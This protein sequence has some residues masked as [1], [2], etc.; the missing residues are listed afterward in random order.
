[1]NK[2]NDN[3][4]PHDSA[5]EQARGHTLV[6][7][8]LVAGLSMIFLT[9]LVGVVYNWVTNRFPP[10][11]LPFIFYITTLL[12]AVT[13]YLIE[14]AWKHYRQLAT[15]GIAPLTWMAL[16]T[17]VLFIAG[18]TLGWYYM[19]EYLNLQM[20]TPSGA[21]L[22]LLSGVHLFHVLL[23]LPFQF[24]FALRLQEKC[25]GDHPDM[26]FLKRTIHR[27]RMRLIRNYWHFLGIVWV[28]LFI[29]LLGMQLLSPA[30]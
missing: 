19:L 20:S 15:E 30:L 7:W 16:F 10:I 26:A 25:S 3:H 17:G 29:V 28:V 13:S 23:V 9:L 12:L 18:Q 22:Y 4:F 11:E 14:G 21:F 2:T 24:R 1:M 8:L 27:T 6:F 5:R